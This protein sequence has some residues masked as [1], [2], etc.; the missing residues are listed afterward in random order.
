MATALAIP[1]HDV[2]NVIYQLLS[3]P[4]PI[5]VQLSEFPEKG[6]STRSSTLSCQSSEI[7][8]D[9]QLVTSGQQSS[10]T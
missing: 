9:L 5:P 3:I 4:G 7:N 6:S 1:T 10:V 8:Q 2:G